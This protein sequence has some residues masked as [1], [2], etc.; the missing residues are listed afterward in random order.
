M[1]GLL[2][3]LVIAAWPLVAEAQQVTESTGSRALGMAGA[4][5]AVADDAS[6]AYWNPAGLASGPAVG[7]TIEWA[8]F[9]TGDQSG[10]AVPGLTL[11]N[12]RFVSLGTWPIGV[13]YGRFSQAEVVHSEDGTANVQGLVTSQ[14]GATILQGVTQGLVIGSTLKYV[15]GRPISAVTRDDSGSDALEQAITTEGDS[16]GTFDL[17]LGVLADMT[18]VRV[19]LTVRNLR[20]PSFGAIDTSATTLPRHARLGLAVLP[21]TG[22]TLAIDADLDTVD[23]RDGPRRMLA[24]GGEQRLGPRWTV[25]SGVRWNLRGVAHP[26]TALGASL[27]IRR[28]MWLDGHYT[29]G[30]LDADRGFGIALRAGF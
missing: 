22:L 13:S 19:G 28:G 26:V 24:I 8:D 2:A 9:R 4:F 11:R 23:L 7:M 15:R 10:P 20:S 30:D 18:R 29:R 14:V 12:A 3:C 16:H 21:T 5:V 27:A 1:R 25:R 17:D 6:A